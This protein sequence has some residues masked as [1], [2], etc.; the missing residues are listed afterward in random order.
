MRH[1]SCSAGV[2]CQLVTLCNWLHGMRICDGQSVPVSV[3]L[4][5]S[6]AVQQA[7]SCNATL[8]GA[9]AIVQCKWHVDA[10]CLLPIPTGQWFAFTAC[11]GTSRC[12][13][14]LLHLHWPMTLDSHSH[15]HGT[16]LMLNSIVWIARV[17]EPLCNAQN[18]ARPDSPQSPAGFW[19]RVIRDRGCK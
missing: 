11:R 14:S 19:A 15:V 1:L 18:P 13:S 6:T 7:A 3:R 4:G 17:A 8:A 10:T 16:F 2:T 12:V 5:H 9:N